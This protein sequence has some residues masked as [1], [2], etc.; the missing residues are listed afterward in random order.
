[1]VLEISFFKSQNKVA[2]KFY[3]FTPKIPQ[4]SYFSTIDSKN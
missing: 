2:V 4:N 3:N 1:M